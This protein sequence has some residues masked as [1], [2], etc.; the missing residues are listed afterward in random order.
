MSQLKS[1][2]LTRLLGKGGLISERISSL[3][4][5]SIF[6]KMQ[7]ITFHRLK[8]WWTVILFIFLKIVPNRKC[9]MRL[10][11]FTFQYTCLF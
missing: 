10:S 3:G 4:E 8:T 11:T 2:I 6:N 1:N 9:H 7:E 5:S